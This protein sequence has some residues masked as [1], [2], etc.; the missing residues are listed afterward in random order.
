MTEAVKMVG[1]TKKFGSVTANNGVDF[2]V[3]A[4]E[5]HS[6]VG[7]NGAGKTTLMRVLYGLYAPT[8]G[9]IWINGEKVEFSS[10]L[11]AIQKGIGMVHQHFM[12][13]PRLTVAENI[14]LG[15]RTGQPFLSWT[16]EARSGVFR[17]FA[18]SIIWPSMWRR[19][20]AISPLECS[21]RWKL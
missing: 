13:I 2:S 16:G 15:E 7:E 1:I 21:R 3:Y 12:L 8:E 11:Q 19:G 6:L 17:R 18:T 9:E 4:G 5:I 14:I 20:S 10:S